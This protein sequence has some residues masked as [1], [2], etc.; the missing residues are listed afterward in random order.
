MSKWVCSLGVFVTTATA[1]LGC[2]MEEV[3]ACINAESSA[4][5]P[6]HVSKPRQE[7]GKYE[8]NTPTHIISKLQKAKTKRKS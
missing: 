1:A 6:L 7:Q 8:E 5:Q 3:E 4:S 2:P